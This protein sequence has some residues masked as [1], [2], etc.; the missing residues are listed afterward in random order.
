MTTI[1]IDLSPTGIASAIRKL[2]ALDLEIQ[3]KTETLVEELTEA[4]AIQAQA[5][6]GGTAAVSTEVNGMNGKIIA[7][8]RAVVIMEFGAGLAT[9]EGHPL[10]GNSPV[11]VKQWEYS[12]T[13][14]SGEGYRRHKWHFPPGS[15]TEYEEVKPRHGILDASDYIKANAEII[16][17]RVFG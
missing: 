6:F 1:R 10:A 8:G 2:E 15:D 17:R 14:G 11:T 9:M 5:A 7:S 3:Q 16:A 4:G 13:V 12:R